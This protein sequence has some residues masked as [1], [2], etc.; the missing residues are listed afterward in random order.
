MKPK[1]EKQPI[2][3]QILSEISPAEQAKISAKMQLAARI[4]D[5]MQIKQWKNKDLMLAIGK[6]NPSE[7]TRWLSGTHNFTVDTL[8]DLERVLEIRLLNVE[9]LVPIKK[10]KKITRSIYLEE[11]FSPSFVNEDKNDYTVQNNDDKQDRF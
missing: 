8:I 9:E 3:D 11:H 10:Q 1:F 2:L 7:I 6:T 4:D 5:A